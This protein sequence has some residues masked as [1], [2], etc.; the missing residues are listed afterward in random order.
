MISILRKIIPQNS[1]I[2]QIFRSLKSFLAALIF[3]FPARKI[4]IIGVTGTDGKTT[5][6][7]LIFHILKNLD[8]KCAKISTVSFS[9]EEKT[10]K[11]KTKR[12]TVSPF[13]MQNFLRKCV[14]EKIQYAVIET[15]SHA[16]AQKRVWGIDFDAAV[17]TNISHEHLDFHGN[18]ENLRQAKKLLFTKFLNSGGICIL[19]A[20]D[21]VSK[22]W[23]NEFLKQGKKVSTFS[24]RNSQ[25]DFYG[26][27]FLD[28]SD[29]LEFMLN[30]QKFTTK[31]F[32]KFNGENCLAAIS[33]CASLPK[34]SNTQ[35]SEIAKIINN[36]SG[37]SGRLENLDF[38]QDFQIFV[39]FG[40]TPQAFEKVL[41]SLQK[42]TAGDLIAV[43][44]A[45]GDHDKSKRPKIGKIAKKYCSKIILTD[46]ETYHEN[47]KQIRDQIK[48]GIF[49][50]EEINDRED[51][52]F[53]EIP[54]RHLAIETAIQIAK[55]NDCVVV[56]GMGNLSSRNMG[57]KEI[58][59]N[60]KQEIAKVFAAMKKIEIGTNLKNLKEKI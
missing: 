6:C 28:K 31:L 15:S 23:K 37:V 45:T 44:G 58:T 35:L 29:G 2:R 1:W 52:N 60:D 25:S 21:E 57:G 48:T 26:K 13:V 40:L 32:G 19:N 20:D 10:W 39:D 43:F 3:R 12:T 49:E 14:K 9:M 54:D 11:N 7:E 4:F 42:R 24:F 51:G 27:N 46:E 59:W 16:L 36:F 22:N 34:I 38:G 8:K 33:L 41:N 17:L 18:L 56:L 50:N 53:F 30:N 55:P 5:T 47:A